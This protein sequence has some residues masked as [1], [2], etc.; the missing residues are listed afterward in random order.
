MDRRER[1]GWRLMAAIAVVS[2][3]FGAAVAWSALAP[4]DS[5]RIS[6]EEAVLTGPAV[7]GPGGAVSWE[8]AWFCNDGV[9]TRTERTAVRSA[10]EGQEQA[11][12]ELPAVSFHPDG[13]SCVRPLKTNIILPNY[14]PPGEYRLRLVTSW[15]APGLKGERSFTTYSPKFTIAP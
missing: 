8:R 5:V 7:V 12:F 11:G 9:T 1:L 15:D 6:T 2:V 3:T 13:A 4:D 10:D 14:L